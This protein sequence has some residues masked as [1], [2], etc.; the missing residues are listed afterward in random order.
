[1]GMTYIYQTEI[2]T[3]EKAAELLRSLDD[4]SI[5]FYSED[6]VNNIHD[7]FKSIMAAKGHAQ[8]LKEEQEA[9]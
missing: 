6:I 7:L 4:E 8:F 5:E 3:L 1:M 2:D 9:R